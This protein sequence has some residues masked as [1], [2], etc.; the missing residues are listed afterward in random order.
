M[1]LL[2]TVKTGGNFFQILVAF[3]E[4]QKFIIIVLPNSNK[5]IDSFQTRNSYLKFALGWTG[6]DNTKVGN[7]RFYK[8]PEKCV[9]K[10]ERVTPSG[11][12]IIILHVILGSC[13]NEVI[14]RYLSRFF[15]A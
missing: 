12:N 15:D 6:L 2:S 3:S 5:Q 9:L 11:K 14:S 8:R 1:R 10:L 4:N 13:I 7:Y